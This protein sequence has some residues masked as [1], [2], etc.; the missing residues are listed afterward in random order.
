MRLL[1]YR[2]LDCKNKN[3]YDLLEIIKDYE[4]KIKINKKI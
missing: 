1:Y 4:N 2:L 3:K